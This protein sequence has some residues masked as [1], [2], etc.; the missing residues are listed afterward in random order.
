MF[1][2]LLQGI[3]LGLGAAVPLGPINVLIMNTALSSARSA[4]G[5][6]FGAMLADLTYLGVVLLGFHLFLESPLIQEILSLLGG[7]FLLYLSLLLYRGRNQSIQERSQKHHPFFK[8]L[9]KGYLLTLSNPY[10]IAFWLSVASLTAS[11]KYQGQWLIVGLVIA[12]LCW[13]TFLPF[14]IYKTKHLISP[15]ISAFFSLFS[16]GV[17]VWFGLTLWVGVLSRWL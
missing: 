16:A 13:I 6:G 7:A 3:L 11:P 15:R 12:I 2:S 1:G 14:L 4:F 8:S 17:M 9:A 10:T 5:V